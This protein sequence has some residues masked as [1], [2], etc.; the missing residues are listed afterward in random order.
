MVVWLLVAAISGHELGVVAWA[1]GGAVGLVAGLVA[2]NPS[3]WYCGAAAVIAGM[4]VVGAKLLMACILMAMSNVSQFLDQLAFYEPE[5]EK[6]AHALA[7]QMIAENQFQGEQLE[8]AK[9]YVSSYFEDGTSYAETPEELEEANEAMQ[10]AVSKRLVSM[11]DEEKQALVVK[12]RTKYPNW[13]ENHE[14]FIAACFL[15]LQDKDQLSDDLAAFARYQ[16]DLENE[17]DLGEEEFS[18]NPVELRK[19]LNQLAA[20]KLATL[21]DEQREQ[22]IG[23]CMKA[24]PH[25]HPYPD[26]HVAMMAKLQSEG[27]FSGPLAEHAQATIDYEMTDDAPDYFDEVDYDEVAKRDLQVGKEINNRLAQLDSQQREQLLRD[28]LAQHPQWEPYN[29][30]SALKAKIDLSLNTEPEEE[31]YELSDGTFS[32]SLKMVCGWMD[33][34]WLFLGVTTAFGT[35]RKQGT[36]A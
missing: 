2:R 34:L 29:E 21:S 10:E 23:D 17:Y 18:G 1:I 22:A 19:Q 33:L 25:W 3:P 31:D 16:I 28:A 11:T 15:L 8:A 20:A 14:D 36:A 4:S 6:Y 26:A 9:F 7:D 5:R 35:A 30:A 12:A 32:G 24:N 13:I 27:V